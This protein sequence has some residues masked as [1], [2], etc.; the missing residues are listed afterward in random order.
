MKA[1]GLDRRAAFGT[2]RSPAPCR[3]V[4]RRRDPPQ[5]RRS[6]SDRR[7]SDAGP[8]AG[9]ERRVGMEPRKPDVREIEM[10]PSE[11]AALTHAPAMPPEPAEPP[12]TSG[13]A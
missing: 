9:R 5:E 6:G 12:T 7:R 13:K 11:W 1:Q 8:P 10:T 2:I 4:N 3:T